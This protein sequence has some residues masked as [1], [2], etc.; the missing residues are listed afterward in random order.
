MAN[1]ALAAMTRRNLHEAL[2]QFLRAHHNAGILTD[3]AIVAETV[4]PNL[5]AEVDER[6]LWLA[7]S[8]GLTSWKLWGLSLAMSKLA[9]QT[10]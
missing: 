2:E 5:D 1:D 9:Y 7:T 8:N 4:E 6:M 3:F 10:A